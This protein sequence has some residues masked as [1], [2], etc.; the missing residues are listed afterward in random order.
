M[1][2]PSS[3]EI[4]CE[5]KLRGV[6]AERLLALSESKGRKPVDVLCDMIESMLLGYD[7]VSAARKA[8][9]QKIPAS[10]PAWVPAWLHED[11]AAIAN[12]EGEES[13]ASYARARKAERRL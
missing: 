9:R 6:L 12:L 1:H 8:E 7:A 3:T 4:D 13:A 10:I 5:I 11:Y 2:K